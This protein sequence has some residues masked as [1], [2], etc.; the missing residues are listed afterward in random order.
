MMKNFM[1]KFKLPNYVVEIIESS[2]EVIFPET[3]EEIIALAFGNKE[4]DFFSVEYEVEGFGKITEASVTRCKNGAVVNYPDDYMRRRDPDCLLVAD[5]NDTDKPKYDDIYNE[6]FEPLRDATFEW[7][8]KQRIIILPFKSGGQE[9]GYDSL[10]IAPVNAAFFACGLADLQGFISIKDITKNFCPKAIIFLAPP[11]RHTH[12]NGKQIVIHNRLEKIHELFSYNLYPGPSAKKGIYGVLLNIGENEGWITVHASTVKVITPYDNEIVIMHEGASGGGKSEMIENIHKEF[13][14]RI[15]LGQNTV[16]GEINYIELKETCELRPVTDDMALCH[17]KMQNKSKKL[18][19]KDAEQGWFLRLD[20]IKAY[21]TT[22]KYEKIFIQPS[23][24]LIFLNIQGIAKS[25]CLVWEHT[26]DSD[27]T[28]CPNPRVILPRR[29]V[30]NVINEPVEVD[31]RS[32]GVR[33]PPCTKENPSYGILGMFHILPPA[34]AWLWRLVAPRGHNNPSITTSVGMSSEGVGS[35]WPFAT[36]K[37]VEQANLLLEQIVSSTN[38]RY[39]LIPNQ[40]IGAYKVGFMPQWIAREYIARRGSAKFKVE[41]LKQARCSLLGYTLESLKVD[42]QYIRKAFLQP[43]MQAEV[44]NEGYDEGARILTEFF[45]KEVEKFN[46][47]LLD[48]LGQQIIQM[49]LN[50]APVEEYS[51]LIP[52][53]Y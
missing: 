4:N 3:R 14:G 10:L 27:G 45:K 29:L 18:V 48:P 11:F 47:P 46:T 19:V 35:Y 53:K 42:G 2:S 7:L 9:Y 1:N 22:P 17:P 20:H 39:V 30:P 31:V 36:G 37:M 6:D 50:N 38:T 32:F 16:T 21:G 28:P 40:H 33:T 24:P 8:K 12:F 34:L 26:I 25:T 15:I 41:H 52:M 13:D 49:F 44:G 51:D 5:D 23:E 43:E